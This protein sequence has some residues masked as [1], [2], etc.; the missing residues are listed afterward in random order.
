MKNKTTTNE[1]NAKYNFILYKP[2]IKHD[3]WEVVDNKVVVYFKVKDPVKKFVGWLYKKS[4]TCDITFDELCSKA[5]LYIDGKKTI[6]DIAKLMSKD[7]NES[8]ESSIKRIVPY[9]KFV[10]QKGW[11]KFI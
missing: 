10:A 5:W 11:I 4:P 2:Q 7:C 3:N 6:Y 8:V 9:M 1:K